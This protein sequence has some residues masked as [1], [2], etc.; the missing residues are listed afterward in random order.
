MP[1]TRLDALNSVFNHQNRLFNAF[2]AKQA[3]IAGT[4]TLTSDIDPLS[5]ALL[6]VT[7]HLDDGARSMDKAVRYLRRKTA[8]TKIPLQGDEWEDM[9]ARAISTAPNHR[10]LL[11]VFDEYMLQSEW[12]K[13][14]AALPFRPGVTPPSQPTSGTST[15]DSITYKLSGS[16]D[17]SQKR[18]RDP[19]DDSSSLSSPKKSR[20]V[21]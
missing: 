9:K 16:R 4:S 14:D 10:T 1:M 6:E 5:A 18:P 15:V 19:F 7:S 20:S 3:V 21:R 2:F 12:P 13:D 8:F 17:S 11:E